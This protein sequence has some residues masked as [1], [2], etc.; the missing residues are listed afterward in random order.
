MAMGM[1]ESIE[2]RIENGDRTK[3][4]ERQNAPPPSEPSTRNARENTQ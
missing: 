3:K 4:G 2:S 1:G